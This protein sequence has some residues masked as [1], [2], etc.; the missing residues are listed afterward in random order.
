MR[1]ITVITFLVFMVEALVHYNQGL[2]KNNPELDQFIIPDN[3]QLGKIAITVLAFSVVT[4]LLIA[5]KWP[6]E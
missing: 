4:S 1:K 5:G 6:T 3:K 2:K